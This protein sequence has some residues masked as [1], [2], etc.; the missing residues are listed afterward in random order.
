MDN[1]NQKLNLIERIVLVI[2]RFLLLLL[3]I[4]NLLFFL[5]GIPTLMC[6]LINRGEKKND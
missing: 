3:A 4:V 6:F 2:S 5:T 1:K